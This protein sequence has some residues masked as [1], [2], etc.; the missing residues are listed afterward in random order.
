MKEDPL[1]D[2]RAVLK[3]AEAKFVGLTAKMVRAIRQA[4]EAPYELE[5]AVKSCLDDARAS[6]DYTATALV[7]RMGV[8]GGRAQYPIL[9]S[10]DAFDRL[11]HKFLP[12][13]AATSPT[14]IAATRQTQPFD[15][16]A[17]GRDLRRL[18]TLSNVLKHRRLLIMKRKA[19]PTPQD[20][21]DR[22]TK[23][24][25]IVFADGTH[26]DWVFA[27]SSESAAGQ[28]FNIIESVRGVIDHVADA[29]KWPRITYLNGPII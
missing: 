28:V 5:L 11:H 17:W 15:G 1:A 14:V 26:A 9:D 13:V 12:G 24:G 6:L 22:M 19:L 29:A 21:L 3:G 2:T 16:G 20:Q 23:G 25:Y 7:D 10:A 18:R 8:A 27:D 4:T